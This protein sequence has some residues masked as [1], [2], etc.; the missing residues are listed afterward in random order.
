MTRK[1]NIMKQAVFLILDDYA[2]WE[3]AHL[4]SMLNQAEE[5]QVKT[6]SINKEVG[7]IGGFRTIVDIT[8]DEIPENIDLLI[9]IG[10]NSWAIE[11][12]ELYYLLEKRLLN[13][14]PVGA[15]C[16]AV[17]YLA[18]KGLLNNF[19]HTGN[20]VYLWKEYTDYNNQQ[21]FL[22]KQAV[23]DHNLVTANGTASLDFAF[24]TLRMI[25][26]KDTASI[27]KEIALQKL[28]FY[29]YSKKYGNPFT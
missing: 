15:I 25:N 13:G 19:K 22:E 8:I 11:N 28:G 7:S 21:N 9:L 18:K 24:E 23:R 4:S 5:W 29:E 14:Q 2:D 16:G 27:E 1:G 3:G 10:G 12:E 17:D 6:A 26:F 20:S